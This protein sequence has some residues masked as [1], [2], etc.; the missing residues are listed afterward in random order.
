MKN[1]A[2]QLNSPCLYASTVASSSFKYEPDVPAEERVLQLHAELQT[3]HAR[4][5]K[6][7]HKQAQLQTAL[8]DSLQKRDALYTQLKG[9]QS[10]VRSHYDSPEALTVLR[11]EVDK[12]DRMIHRLKDTEQLDRLVVLDALRRVVKKAQATAQ[13]QALLTRHLPPA[14]EQQLDTLRPS[15]AVVKVLRFAESLLELAAAPPVTDQL[16]RV[17]QLNEEMK[18]SIER[19]KELLST[20]KRE[21]RNKSQ[22]TQD[23]RPAD[24]P[25][26]LARSSTRIS[27]CK[28]PVQQTE[29]KTDEFLSFR[30]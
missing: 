22:V 20:P 11:A 21:P 16:T 29:F 19:S 1:S 10:P 26:K 6:L 9:L 18:A 25:G 17:S 8:S 12:R 7:E 2:H 27:I 15:E 28:P 30:L 24:E 14:F 3:A 4:I 5:K 23:R 13:V